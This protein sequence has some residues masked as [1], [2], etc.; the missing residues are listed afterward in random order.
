[1]QHKHFLSL[2]LKCSQQHI[3]ALSP[4]SVQRQFSSVAEVVIAEKFA[5]KTSVRNRVVTTSFY[6]LVCEKRQHMKVLPSAER[7]IDLPISL[8]C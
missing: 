1:M 4:S 7:L 5:W 8:M 6:C 3:T 2:H